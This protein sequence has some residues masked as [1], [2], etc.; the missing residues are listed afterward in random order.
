MLTRLL[1]NYRNGR[2]HHGTSI[3]DASEAFALAKCKAK[4]CAERHLA[5]PIAVVSVAEAAAASRI[6]ARP[7][8][9]AGVRGRVLDMMRANHEDRLGCKAFLAVFQRQQTQHGALLSWLHKTL[10]GARISDP[11]ER[12]MLECAMTAL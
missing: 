5:P 1:N 2:Q 6:W 9:N 3:C 12:R 11:A 4:S 8:T 7:G 10:V